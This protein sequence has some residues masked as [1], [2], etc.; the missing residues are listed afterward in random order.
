[1]I[2]FQ[3]SKY[4]RSSGFSKINNLQVPNAHV[5]AVEGDG[6][7]AANGGSHS[8]GIRYLTLSLS[9]PYRYL[10]VIDPYPT[11]VQV[12]DA[13]IPISGRNPLLARQFSAARPHILVMNKMDLIDMGKYRYCG[14]RV[15]IVERGISIKDGR[16]RSTMRTM[17]RRG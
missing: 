3:W 10:I 9:Y 13:R 14:G 15:T 1:M 7:Q 12:H 2:Q 8:G 16:S 17:A 4:C 5:S 11:D 6:G